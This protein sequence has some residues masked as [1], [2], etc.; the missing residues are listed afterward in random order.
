M[1]KEKLDID[2]IVRYLQGG[3]DNTSKDMI[4]KIIQDDEN[5]RLEFDKYID[6]WEKSASVG[7]F[8]KVN[9]EKDWLKVRSRMN[10]RGNRK[11]IP[12]RSYL[13]RIAAILILA[14]GLTYLL[15]EVTKTTLHK[16]TNYLEF[17]AID[18][19]REIILP[20]GSVAFLNKHSK[21][22]RPSNFGTDNRDI[23]L[24]GEAFFE[25]T[26]NKDLPFKVHT[27]NS[28]VEVVGTS[29]N[30]HTDSAQVVVSVV[31]G[32]V[33]FYASENITNRIELEP[34][35]TGIFEIRTESL[36]PESSLDYNQLAWHTGKF[37][38][39]NMPLNKVCN[40]L[41][42]FYDLDFIITD[43]DIEFIDPINGE[44]PTD[45]LD[46][47]IKDINSALTEDIV[48]IANETRLI[49]SKQ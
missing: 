37:D 18:E 26:G 42:E 35:N 45:S 27:L 1:K 10:L 4:D 11:R 40:V 3:S 22:I 38:F 8:E 21:I 44:F 48:L 28:T 24:E 33:A 19:T 36:T 2:L 30:V 31:S 14:L 5:S 43:Q 15:V 13:I 12:I 9:T 39:Q 7:D 20:D 46:E 32:K 17:A 49:V 34:E 6:V 47:I 16:D 25:V 29:F 41:A 23:I